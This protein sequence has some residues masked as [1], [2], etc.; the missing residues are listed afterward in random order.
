MISIRLAIPLGRRESDRHNIQSWLY[1]NGPLV[2]AAPSISCSAEFRSLSGDS[3][4]NQIIQ[5]KSGWMLKASS[6]PRKN[7]CAK[8][9]KDAGHTPNSCWT[10][11]VCKN[12][13]KMQNAKMKKCF[14]FFCATDEPPRSQYGIPFPL[15]LNLREPGFTASQWRVLALRWTLG[16]RVRCVTCVNSLQSIEA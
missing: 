7:G 8:P 14:F 2:L 1:Q 9:C 13:Y 15:L 12:I 5:V 3:F 4:F 16:P 6:V 11:R 10:H